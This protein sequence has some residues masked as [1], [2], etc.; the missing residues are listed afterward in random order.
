[1]FSRRPEISESNPCFHKTGVSAAKRRTLQPMRY[2][3]G[4]IVPSGSTIIK[5]ALSGRAVADSPALATVIEVSSLAIVVR[6]KLPDEIPCRI[7]EIETTIMVTVTIT[8]NR[9]STILSQVCMD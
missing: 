8:D 7:N 6:I 9:I 4:K 1:M 5:N 3:W 2:P